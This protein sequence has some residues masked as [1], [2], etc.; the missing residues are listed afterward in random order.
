MALCSVIDQ[1]KTVCLLLY[2]TWLKAWPKIQIDSSIH[3]LNWFR[4]STFCGDF[5]KGHKSFNYFNYIFRKVLSSWIPLCIVFVILL[6]NTF[7]ILV[8]MGRRWSITCYMIVFQNTI[9]QISL[10]NKHQLYFAREIEIFLMEVEYS[11]HHHCYFHQGSRTF[12]Y[13]YSKEEY[14]KEELNILAV[15]SC[16]VTNAFQSES[17]LY[18]CLNVKELLA[19]SSREIWSF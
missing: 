16:H 8:N 3:C 14:S 4:S 11:H 12:Y 5:D 1:F 15:R 2:N 18:S 17:T 13:W 6:Q 9:L 7:E 10:S 19:W